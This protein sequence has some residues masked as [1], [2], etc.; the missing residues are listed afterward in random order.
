MKTKKK[1]QSH[2][3]FVIKWKK[4]IIGNNKLFFVN[5]ACTL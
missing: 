1:V 2:K 4:V 3:I 5:Y